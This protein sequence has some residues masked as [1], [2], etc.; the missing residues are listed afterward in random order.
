LPLAPIHPVWQDAAFLAILVVLARWVAHATPFL[1]LAAF[2]LTYLIGLTFLLAVTRTWPSFFAMGFLWPSLILTNGKSL[3]LTLIFIV[4]ALVLW[5]G[6]RKSL[7]T[8]PWNQQIRLYPGML[9]PLNATP[10]LQ[11]E[12]RL[13]G[14]NAMG[15]SSTVG[16]PFGQLSPKVRFR[17]ISTAAGFWVSLLAAWWAYCFTVG[18]SVA[19]V[20]ELIFLL[21]LFGATFRVGT[22]C[23]GLAL[24]ST[25]RSRFVRGQFIVPGFDQVLVAP[26]IAFGVT[27]VGSVVIG[28][29]GSSYPIVQV[30]FIFWILFILFAGGPT[31]RNWVLTG[32]HR[33]TP[34]FQGA[35]RQTFRPV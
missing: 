21:G 4:M 25:L 16:W 33:F 19:P 30:L 20:R 17:S 31:M 8:F 23:A 6:T 32:K 11:R 24:P 14:V 5:H 34:N 3:P 18:F 26:L 7:Q 27:I 28:H 2:G 15:L 10:L 29:S 35:T 13:E 9:K 1:P 22:Y 12:I